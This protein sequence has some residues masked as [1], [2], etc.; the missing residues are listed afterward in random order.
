MVCLVLHH[1]STSPNTITYSYFH[2]RMQAPEENSP[3]STRICLLSLGRG[4]MIERPG[5]ELLF[6]THGFESW[7]V[8][9]CL[10]IS[11]HFISFKF[12]GSTL[13][14]SA[15]EADMYGHTSSPL[16]LG[17][18]EGIFFPSISI[19]SYLPVRSPQAGIAT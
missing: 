4:S 19:S 2:F 14:P 16:G 17:P 13:S 3:Y 1:S 9:V 6:H 10:C 15:P 5:P 11:F 7:G 18:E 8:A 12:S